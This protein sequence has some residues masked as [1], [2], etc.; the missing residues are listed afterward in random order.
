MNKLIEAAKL[1]ARIKWPAMGD[2][3]LVTHLSKKP[4]QRH[5]D[6]YFFRHSIGEQL[7]YQ[8]FVTPGGV[9]FK[10]CYSEL[11]NELIIATY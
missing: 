8:E 6:A 3:T 1:M 9:Q 7:E 11:F 5:A 2:D 4:P 10:M